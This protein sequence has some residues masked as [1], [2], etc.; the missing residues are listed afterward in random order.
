MLR[1]EVQGTLARHFLMPN[2]HKFFA[3]YPEIEIAMSESDRWV[4]VIREGSDCVLR[5][6]ALPDSD[7]VARQVTSLERITCAA[8]SYLEEHGT[9]A[10]LDDLANHTAV[11]L[12]SVTTGALSPLEFVEDGEIAKVDMR[13]PFSV[14]SPESFLEAAR[15]GFGLAQVP[16]FHLRHDLAAGRLHRVLADHPVPRGPVSILYPRARQ[17]SPRVRVFIDWAI[18]QFAA[19]AGDPFTSPSE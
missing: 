17:L 3:S 13:V 2:L 15:L 14:T 16:L 9:P 10:N 12:R 1:I 7:L 18:Q 19:K 6:G 4:D 11:C 8:T 5:Y